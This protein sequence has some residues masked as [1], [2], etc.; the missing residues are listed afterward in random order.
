MH[1]RRH[2]QLTCNITSLLFAREVHRKRSDCASNGQGAA[3]LTLW[4]R[5]EGSLSQSVHRRARREHPHPDPSLE[6]PVPV[7]VTVS[8]FIASRKLAG[9][10]I[11]EFNADRDTDGTLARRFVDAVAKALEERDD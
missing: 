7:C 1:V 10:V 3:T 11:T 4:H 8:V 9:L 6:L 5:K 2:H